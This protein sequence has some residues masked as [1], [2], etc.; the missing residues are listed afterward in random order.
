[1]E[2]WV[3]IPHVGQMDGNLSYTAL[4]HPQRFDGGP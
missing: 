3:A 2:T 1:M 4:S